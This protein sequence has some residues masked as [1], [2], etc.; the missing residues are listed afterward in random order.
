MIPP[1]RACLDFCKFLDIFTW[2]ARSED[3]E[4]VELLWEC[5]CTVT[6]QARLCTS[7]KDV[8]VARIQASEKLK[9][10]G[11]AS[12]SDAF[13]TFALLCRKLG[14]ESVSQG[15]ALKLKFNGSSYNPSMHKAA[16]QV[17]GVM[18][19]TGAGIFFEAIQR[20]ELAWGRELLSNAYSKLVKLISVAKGVAH[21]HRNTQEIAAWLVDMLHLALLCKSTTVAKATDTFLDKD[22]KHGSHGFW[23][24]C[25]VLLQAGSAFFLSFGMVG[26]VHAPFRS[27]AARSQL[28]VLY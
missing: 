23:P 13:L 28:L 22:R 15:S 26:V 8:P 7:D 20:L 18:G 17:I 6:M 12:L 24:A 5:G 27:A 2:H 14:V 21:V 16:V 4:W 10:I 25:L 1:L 19:P 9:A 11:D 3:K